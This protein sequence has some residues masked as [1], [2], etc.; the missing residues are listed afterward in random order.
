MKNILA[1][2]GVEFLAVFLG[3][4]LSL[5]VDDYR[6]S[7]NMKKE[8]K[9]SLI[10]LEIEITDNIKTLNYIL[11]RIDFNIGFTEKLLNTDILFK[12]EVSSKDSIWNANII[13]LSSK[14]S[15]SAY[16]NFVSSGLIYKINDEKLIYEIQ[17]IYESNVDL[18][19]WWVDYETKFIEHIDKYI[20]KNLALDKIGANWELDW[21]NEVTLKGIKTTEFQNIIIGNRAN[22]E[23]IKEIA[24]Q[25]IISKE[26]L[27]KGVKSYNSSI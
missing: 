4:G 11:K 6:D 16:D 26:N 23:I 15:K 8:I 10:A 13:P 20:F 3:I 12:Q 2:G 17:T 21:Q 24:G 22:R 18:F 5:W 14:L 27:L 19:E 1:K 9:S 25:L 7:V